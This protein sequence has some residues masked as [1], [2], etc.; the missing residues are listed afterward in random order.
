MKVSV[1][2]GNK[3]LNVNID[4]AGE[5]HHLLDALRKNQI[6]VQANCGGAGLCGKC[7]IK[8]EEGAPNPSIQDENC[9]SAEE[10]AAGWRLACTVEPKDL[11]EPVTILVPQTNEDE[12]EV[13]VGGVSRAGAEAEKIADGMGDT[14][15]PTVDPSHTYGIAVD[16]GTTTVAIALVDMDTTQEVDHFATVNHQRRFGADVISRIK[17]AGE[18]H[19]EE[20]QNSIRKD[21]KG[22]IETLLNTYN[23]EPAS[24]SKIVIAG[25]TTMGHLFMGFSCDS[26]GRAPYTPVDISTIRRSATEI[27]GWENTQ[28]EVILL[29]GISTY[30]GADITAGMYATGM[31]TSKELSVLVDLGTNGE[32]AI[33]NEE[34][35]LVTSTAAGPAFEGGNI[36]CGVAS[37]PGAICSVAIDGTTVEVKTIG[38]QT[39]VGLC[40]TGVIETVYEL[41]KAEWI[42]YSGRLEDDYFDDGVVL[43]KNA[44]GEELTF[45]QEDV[46]EVQ[47]AKSAVRA[48]L[49]CL[50]L[51]FGATY[52]DV[53]NVYI[54]GGFGYKMDL[55]KAAGIGM[56]PEELL[57]KMQA[58]GN[59][60]LSGALE[61][62]KNPKTLAEME[63]I[64]SNS[65]EV[66]LATTKEFND[67]YM[68]YMMFE[69]DF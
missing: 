66:N 6:E 9:L 60:S 14:E 10:L 27:F 56:L 22:G 4:A 40:G 35:F 29:P 52:E 20:M 12:M 53:A 49:E 69:D 58:V 61:A 42:D 19:L 39:P 11:V 64:V 45:L 26:L 24:L 8:F 47:L 32:M 17:A 37:V 41:M 63:A 21:L 59:S 3:L 1:K 25:N 31:H 36:S 13:Q 62:L 28:A 48:G 68:E 55:K 33:G 23:L 30:V 51:K 38:E 5:D 57:P 15:T 16:I 7:K 44:K 54:A 50:L 18:G 67:F 34:K 43:A 46:R 65:E 2:Y